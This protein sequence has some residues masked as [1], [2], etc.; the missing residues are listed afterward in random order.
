M[1]AKSLPGEQ[2]PTKNLH[3]KCYGRYFYD[4]KIISLRTGS[5]PKFSSKIFHSSKNFHH[6]NLVE[7]VFMVAIS[8]PQKQV[9]TKNFHQNS[10][11]QKFFMVAKSF[12]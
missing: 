11:G 7:N 6:N 2:D 9:P 12:P 4:W 8:F 10:F 1:V 5:H 3:Q